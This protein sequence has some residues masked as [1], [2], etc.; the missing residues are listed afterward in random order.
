MAY[1]FDISDNNV[2]QPNKKIIKPVNIIDTQNPP[3]SG[4][5]NRTDTDYSDPNR[6]WTSDEVIPNLD[7]SEDAKD[8]FIDSLPEKQK[9]F[10]YLGLGFLAYYLFLS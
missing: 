7:L 4:G 9:P 3:D 1:G 5:G 6:S 10:A 8:S 2:V